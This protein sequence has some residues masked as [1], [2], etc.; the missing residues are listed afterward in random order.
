MHA[1]R[2]TDDASTWTPAPDSASG[3]SGIG[4][5]AVERGEFGDGE[6][7]FVAEV[8]GL[9]SQLVPFVQYCLKGVKMDRL[10]TGYCRLAHWLRRERLCRG[11]VCR[12]RRIRRRD[13][14]QGLRGGRE[15]L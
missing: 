13:K 11:C 2:H 12:V 15:E 4:G 3:D 9:P 6:E 1:V 7:D 5:A 10:S 8:R 14:Y